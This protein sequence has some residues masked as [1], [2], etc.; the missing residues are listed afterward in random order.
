MNKDRKPSR[1]IYV[2]FA[3]ALLFTLLTG[4]AVPTQGFQRR[5]ARARPRASM[6]VY[7]CPMHPEVTSRK[8]GK[9]P[10]C[11]M[12][13]RRPTAATVPTGV[14]SSS[15]VEAQPTETS[16]AATTVEANSQPPRIPD[17][18]VYDQDNRRLNFYTDLIKGKTV[19]INFIFTTCTTICPPLTATFR[20]V[21]QE[22]GA[23]SGRNVQLISISV[24]PTVD[25]P[26]RLKAFS[27]QFKAG[28]GW[29]FVTGS[30]QDIDQ[31][32]KS[33]GAY[34]SDKN[35]HTPMILVGNDSAKFWT[36]TYGLASA[37][38]LVKVVDEA[39]AQ[40]PAASATG[41]GNSNSST[42]SVGVASNSQGEDNKQAKNLTPDEAAASY[43]PNTV[44][45]TQDNKPVRFY[46]DLLKG[47]VVLINFMFATC[48]GV[49]SPMTANLAK[50]QGYLGERLGRDIVMISITVDPETDTPA[51]L[52]KYAESH[53]VMPGWY[54]LT[55][56]K[57]NVDWVLY[58]L[59][60]YVEDK[61][62]HTAV[63][64][65]GNVSTGEWVKMH[66]MANPTEIANAVT[67][68][69]ASKKTE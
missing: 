41:S 37:A 4:E 21:Q 56:E 30:R 50:V 45:V 51:A 43:F 5:A 48:K 54:F 28:P 35:D 67:K 63:L 36:R 31:L 19:I 65:A 22:L 13:L 7:A 52:K 57:K 34:V 47:K 2:A 6:V 23:R 40:S 42:M 46:S 18:T 12:T 17:V 26:E 59:G 64:I 11:G 69:L 25:V 15:D 9:C 53:K 49:C 61:S 44:L 55:G 1:A 62:E 3:L 20:R 27:D 10:K 8:P 29:S 68:L 39:A 16:A 60:G 14:A 38:T 33:L 66:A 24:D 58:K 32:L